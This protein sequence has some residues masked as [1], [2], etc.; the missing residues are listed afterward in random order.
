MPSRVT[1]GGL[2]IPNT[3]APASFANGIA[4]GWIGYEQR[5]ADLTNIGA[6]EV[7]VLSSAVTVNA[8][9]RIE[10]RAFF[11]AWTS[12]VAGDL[13]QMRL[14][15]GST[16]LQ[17]GRSR[18]Q[19]ANVATESPTILYA[20]LTPTTGAHTYTMAIARTTGSGTL[21]LSGGADG[22]AHLLV[23]DLGP[24]S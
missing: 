14:L 10:V 11:P 3:P 6:T 24:S 5:T 4:G 12:T 20:V 8:G 2:Q 7:N 19:L 16:Q 15:E 1:P 13:A 9:R 18:T 22:P 21:I 17:L 23:T